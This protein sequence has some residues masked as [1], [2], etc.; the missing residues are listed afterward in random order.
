MTRILVI[1]PDTNAART[2]QSAWDDVETFT[3]ATLDD[4]AS[5]IK[6]RTIEYAFLDIEELRPLSAGGAHFP[7]RGGL[8]PSGSGWRKR[9][10]RPLSGGV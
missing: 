8:A 1:T 7:L 9:A 2:I 10:P 4:A 6:G 5:I 3:A